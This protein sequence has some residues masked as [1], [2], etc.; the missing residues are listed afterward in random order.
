[1]KRHIHAAFW[2]VVL[3]ASADAASAH[4][5]SAI[6]SQQRYRELTREEVY[7]C[8]G[9]LFRRLALKQEGP[10]SERF[11]LEANCFA[12][13]ATAL[14]RIA[15]HYINGE[16]TS[17]VGRWLRRVPIQER[18]FRVTVEVSDGS[19]RIAEPIEVIRYVG[20]NQ[21]WFADRPNLTPIC[22]P[23]LDRKF[24][25]YRS[26]VFT[27]DFPRQTNL[28]LKFRLQA[29]VAPTDGA[30]TLAGHLVTQG[31]GSA[32]TWTGVGIFAA[33]PLRAV[34]AT[35]GVAD[36]AKAFVKKRGTRGAPSDTIAVELNHAGNHLYSGDQPIISKL[37][38]P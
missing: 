34:L 5:C 27:K 30:A 15:E 2:A 38:S 4:D 1:M 13:D 14:R 21:W 17:W 3:F 36:Y 6:A 8:A 29:A 25:P 37:W 23:N 35:S 32:I 16:P 22:E 31:A 11:Q 28:V 19:Q 9:E 18:A 10:Q 24:H 12:L 26:W 20:A 33:I 7:A